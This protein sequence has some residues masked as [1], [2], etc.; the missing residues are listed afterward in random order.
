MIKILM[1]VITTMV[2]CNVIL[3]NLLL[4]GVV[5]LTL[6]FGVGLFALFTFLLG[7]LCVIYWD[8]HL[9]R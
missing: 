8:E 9:L 3:L 1:V 5:D 2:F 6:P 7:F 4:T